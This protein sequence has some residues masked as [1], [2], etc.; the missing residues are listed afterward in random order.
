MSYSIMH[1]LPIFSKDKVFTYN[2]GFYIKAF[3]G[4]DSYLGC[5]KT[6]PRKDYYAFITERNNKIGIFRLGRIDSI[7]FFK[8]KIE[9]DI[10]KVLIEV[11]PNRYG[12]I[13]DNTEFVPKMKSGYLCLI[14]NNLPMNFFDW[15]K[16]INN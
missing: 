1:N 16:F 15:I 10:S 9:E 3:I 12:S 13:I 5:F 6:S 7:S 11:I 14:K 2:G 8:L 4:S